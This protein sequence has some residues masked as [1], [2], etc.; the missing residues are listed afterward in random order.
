MPETLTVDDLTSIV[1]QMRN[2]GASEEEIDIVV[3]QLSAKLEQNTSPSINRPFPTVLKIPRVDLQVP[4]FGLGGTP[5]EKPLEAA[6]ARNLRGE[7]QDHPFMQ[8]HRNIML[9]KDQME[10]L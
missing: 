9:K 1:D 3:A 8:A 10:K 7:E 4:E 5:S 2:N 6:I